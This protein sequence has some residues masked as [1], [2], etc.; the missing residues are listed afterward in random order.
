MRFMRKGT[1]VIKAQAE[2]SGKPASPVTSESSKETFVTYHNS[3]FSLR[4]EKNYL[5]ST[6]FVTSSPR[7]Y[8]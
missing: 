2:I 6:T 4:V 7:N 1:Q 5:Y 8:I 3:V